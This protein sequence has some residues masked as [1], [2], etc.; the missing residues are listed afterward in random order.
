MIFQK[1]IQLVLIQRI[2][3][4]LEAKQEII[5]L[6]TDK[7]LIIYEEDLRFKLKSVAN[8]TEL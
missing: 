5:L 8:L 2:L 3:I 6:R 1:R 7:G 4:G